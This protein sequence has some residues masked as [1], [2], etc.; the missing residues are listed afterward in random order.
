[1]HHSES[2]SLLGVIRIELF[3]SMDFSCRHLFLT[4]EAALGIFNIEKG[5]TVFVALSSNG[6][7]VKVFKGS[8]SSI[9]LTRFCPISS[10]PYVDSLLLFRNKFASRP[11][12]CDRFH[13][14]ASGVFVNSRKLLWGMTPIKP[15]INSDGWSVYRHED[16]QAAYSIC[17]YKKRFCYLSEATFVPESTGKYNRD[18]LSG[19]NLRF[20]QHVTVCPLSSAP[21]FLCGNGLHEPISVPIPN[22]ITCGATDS[23]AACDFFDTVEHEL[24]ILKSRS[25]YLSSVD[26]SVKAESIDGNIYI[27]S[28]DVSSHQNTCR[29]FPE[30]IAVENWIPA[31]NEVP[32]IPIFQ[33]S[34][35]STDVSYHDLNSRLLDGADFGC[36]S[37]GPIL[38]LKGDYFTFYGPGFSPSAGISM[39]ASLLNSFHVEEDTG[40]EYSPGM[41]NIPEVKNNT[42]KNV[43]RNTTFNKYDNIENVNNNSYNNG[44]NI[45]SD[46]DIISLLSVYRK[47]AV[48]LLE[49]RE[50]LFDR[51]QALSSNLWLPDCL[52]PIREERS[53]AHSA[54]NYLQNSIRSDLRNVPHDVLQ[55]VL[56]NVPQNITQRVS[57]SIMS[58]GVIQSRP[59]QHCYQMRMN[60]PQQNVPQSV[61]NV[62]TSFGG[63]YRLIK[64][65]LHQLPTKEIYTE[66]NLRST[67]IDDYCIDENINRG[68]SSYTGSSSSYGKNINDRNN[69]DNN[70]NKNSRSSSCQNN[71]NNYDNQHYHSDDNK[72]SRYKTR[73]RVRQENAQDESIHKNNDNN[74]VTLYTATGEKFTAYPSK[75]SEINGPLNYG[76]PTSSNG[77]RK[78]GAENLGQIPQNE[79]IGFVIKKVRGVFK[80]RTHIEI[81]FGSKVKRLLE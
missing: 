65:I 10:L 35:L 17:P 33:D 5:T 7:F 24:H 57:S 40:G 29:N 4:N 52:R 64:G 79:G 61:Q 45:Y 48:K 49:Y 74:N 68:N 21:A 72:Y 32:N 63:S 13:R 16:G 47:N 54:G 44:T 1:M 80:N 69:N 50:H 46:L 14:A 34:L 53:S 39:H 75:Y 12:L 15:H 6:E 77:V 76:I 2:Q 73:E 22:S 71:K 3:S 51:Q 62:P 56:Q 37:R 31:R 11:Y 9:H 41:K 58:N 25:R 60:I 66:E 28:Y 59:S 38:A 23:S 55:N 30:D 78:T 67:M 70:N 27:C 43:P 81:C 42:G 19:E 8:S 26:F 20:I 36:N 18:G